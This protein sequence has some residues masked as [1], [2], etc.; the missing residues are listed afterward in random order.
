MSASSVVIIAPIASCNCP[1]IVSSC[2]QQSYQSALSDKLLGWDEA[3]EWRF[4]AFVAER[5]SQDHELAIA[6]DLIRFLDSMTDGAILDAS[7]AAVYHWTSAD[8]WQTRRVADRHQ[9][10]ADQPLRR[11]PWCDLQ[12]VFL[13]GPAALPGAWG[14]GLKEVVNALGALDPA[15]STHWPAD[16]DAG[17]HAMVMAWRAYQTAEP[18]RSEEIGLIKRYLEADCCALRQILGWLRATRHGGENDG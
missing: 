15:W 17:A 12:Q 1:K 7:R 3:G 9:L 2:Q 10:P 11:L 4:K 13:D 8:V 16:L 18:S 6:E 5:E 14:F